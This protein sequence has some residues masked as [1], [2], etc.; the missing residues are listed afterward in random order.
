MEGDRHE[1]RLREI[2]KWMESSRRELDQ[3]LTAAGID[4]EA[5]WKLDVERSALRP[6]LRIAYD[7]I[8]DRLDA[9]TALQPTPGSVR[10]RI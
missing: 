3:A 10:I 5:F 9:S 6:E 4:P 8:T 7:E 2:E 1:A